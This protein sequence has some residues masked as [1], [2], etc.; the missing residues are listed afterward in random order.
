MIPIY[1]KILS[2]NI[3]KRLLRNN[4]DKFIIFSIIYKYNNKKNEM[5]ENIF[6]E[7]VVIKK[8]VYTHNP[9]FEK[10]ISQKISK[11]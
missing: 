1:T 4:K 2:I 7:R 3:I 5:P 9:I 8:K 11:N 6:Y 10:F